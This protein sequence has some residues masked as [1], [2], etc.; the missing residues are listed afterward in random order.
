[1]AQTRMS[2]IVAALSA[3][4]LIVAAMWAWN[5]AVNLSVN[6]A[7]PEVSA[8]AWR[9]GAVAVFAA[10]QLLILRFVVG[11]VYRQDRTGDVMKLAAIL[12]AT[13]SLISAAALGV[14]GL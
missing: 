11:A 7:R 3:I 8:M 10:A 9:S 6:S 14:A 13:V 2:V 1:M 12:V 5:G 4:F